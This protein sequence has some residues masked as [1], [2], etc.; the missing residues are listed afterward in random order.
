MKA[1]KMHTGT[2]IIHTRGMCVKNPNYAVKS[3]FCLPFID[4]CTHTYSHIHTKM[5][6]TFVVASLYYCFKAS[7]QCQWHCPLENPVN[8]IELYSKVN[9]IKI[10]SRFSTNTQIPANTQTHAYKHTSSNQSK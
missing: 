5:I 3:E 7:Q 9:D 2:H 10:S 4:K 6:C 1:H 8:K